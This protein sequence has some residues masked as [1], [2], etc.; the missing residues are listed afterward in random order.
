[1]NNQ[2]LIIFNFPAIYETLSEIES[3]LNFKILNLDKKDLS[4]FDKK[5]FSELHPGGK[6]GKKLKTLKEIMDTDIP[7]IQSNSQLY[8]IHIPDFEVRL[9]IFMK[10]ENT[11]I[12]LRI[13]R[14][15]GSSSL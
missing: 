1:M 11:V 3:K 5:S 4:K 12:F 14:F 8:D 13:R 2:N 10:V 9:I 6:I 15:R 7:S